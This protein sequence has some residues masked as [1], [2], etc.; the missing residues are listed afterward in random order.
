MDDNKKCI[1][2][3]LDGNYTRILVFGTN[4]GSNTPQNRRYTATYIYVH[5]NAPGNR[6]SIPGQVIPKTQKIVL[7]AFLLSTQHYKARINGK[8]N[9]P[10][11][12]VAPAP[13]PRCISY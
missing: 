9:N 2:K 1:G 5:V 4:P 3:R 10:G 8:W 6:G 13:I 7:D 12:R 11:K